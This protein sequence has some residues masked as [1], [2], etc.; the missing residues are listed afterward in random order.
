M[1]LPA[2]VV[3]KILVVW[4]VNGQ[5]QMNRDLSEHF[6]NLRRL[7]LCEQIDLK[8]EMIASF[9]CTVDCILPYQD[10]GRQQNGL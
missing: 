8:V 1:D 5:F 6:E 4:I 9:G 7:L 10:E 3:K 2:Y